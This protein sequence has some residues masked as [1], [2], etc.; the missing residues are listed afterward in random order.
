MNYS[1]SYSYSSQPS[2]AMMIVCLLV[3]VVSIVAMWKLYTKAGKPGWAALIPFYNIWVL[4][5]IV[6]NRGT[7]MFRLLIPFY[8]IYWAIKTDIELAHAYG[9]S[10]GFGVGLIFLGPIFECI[11]AFG[12]ARY[13]GPQNM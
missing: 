12:N 1:Y 2:P 7:A 10:T 3:A 6:C 13:V 11:L 4:Y 9:Q 5:E 8:N